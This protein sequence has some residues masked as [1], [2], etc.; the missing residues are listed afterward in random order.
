MTSWNNDCCLWI[1][2]FASTLFSVQSPTIV[3]VLDSI[4]NLILHFQVQFD[5]ISENRPNL[6]KNLQSHQKHLSKQ[7]LEQH[8]LAKFKSCSSSL[9]SSNSS[10][11]ASY[12]EKNVEPICTSC[13]R[14]TNSLESQTQSLSK[15]LIEMK[16]NKEKLSAMLHRLEFIM[17]QKDTKLIISSTSIPN[18]PY[19]MLDKFEE[20]FY[21]F[22]QKSDE[23][24]R[25]LEEEVASLTNAKKELEAEVKHKF[26]DYQGNLY[27]LENELQA[28]KNE[29]V[30][31]KAN[32]ENQREISK[33]LKEKET[34]LKNLVHQIEKHTVEEIMKHKSTK[35]LCEQLK[36]RIKSLKEIQ[37]HCETDLASAKED[38]KKLNFK[39]QRQSGYLQ[40]LRNQK[41][42]SK[43]EEASTKESFEECIQ[44]LEETRTK[45]S[46]EKRLRLRLEAKIQGFQSRIELLQKLLDEKEEIL[47]KETPES[48][49]GIKKPKPELLYNHY[50]LNQYKLAISDYIQWLY[51]LNLK[52]KQDKEYDK[53]SSSS[54]SKVYKSL[55]NRLSNTFLSIPYDELVS[56]L[57]K[58]R[59]KNPCQT[60]T[61]IFSTPKNLRKGLFQFLKDC[62]T[63]VLQTQ[64]TAKQS[65]SLADE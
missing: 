45:L 32:Y 22:N 60:L 57:E 62:T 47:P 36:C 52:D 63:E 17:E 9:T 55:I 43:G 21:N 44:T 28:T 16:N 24:L 51:S 42:L 27:S 29:V 4:Q 59:Q 2:P 33:K 65:M 1:H 31:F 53:K 11:A 19:S 56:E 5:S 37:E 41:L 3:D 18:A 58:A 64:N 14:L 49:R 30:E 10:L 7:N 6:H 48:K 20:A 54:T 46:N 15:L 35:E 40:Q 39:L 50:Q 61:S 26:Q 25:K 13:L 38:S 23:K 8:G 34:C 12:V